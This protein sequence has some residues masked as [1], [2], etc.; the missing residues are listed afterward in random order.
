MICLTFFI[1]TWS[2]YVMVNT[3][4]SKPGL[5]LFSLQE[6]GALWTTLVRQLGGD[7]P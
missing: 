5:D 7:H 3:A 6:M 2:M 1:N 4:V